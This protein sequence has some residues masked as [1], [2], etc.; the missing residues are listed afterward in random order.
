LDSSS[1]FRSTEAA[2]MMDRKPFGI[3]GEMQLGQ[4]GGDAISYR[5]GISMCLYFIRAGQRVQTFENDGAPVRLEP[6][7]ACP[8]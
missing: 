7:R 4:P 1:F 5:N 8:L 6:E 2:E 3:P